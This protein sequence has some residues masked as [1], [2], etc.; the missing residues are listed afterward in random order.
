MKIFSRFLLAVTLVI[1]A[2]AFS[3]EIWHGYTGIDYLY[4]ASSGYYVLV[5]NALPEYSLC[6]A[7]K[8]F[9]IPLTHANYDSLV[10]TLIAAA[11]SNKEIRINIGSPSEASCAPEIN[12]MFMKI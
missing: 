9:Y 3:N 5:T 10:D 8:R 12:R 11:V 7:G 4:P 6:D 1:S 2:N